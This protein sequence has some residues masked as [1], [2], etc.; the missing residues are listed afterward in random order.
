MTKK[1]PGSPRVNVK[2]DDHLINMAVQNDS[3]HCMIAEGVKLAWPGAR[4]VS[5]DLQTIRFSDPVTRMRYT[6]LTPRIAQKA[7]CE[8]DEGI[9]PEPIVFQLREGQVTRS[10]RKRKDEP[11]TQSEKQSEA[12]REGLKQAHLIIR[13]QDRIP[14]R[15]GG[16]TPPIGALAGGDEDALTKIP[17]GRRR[18]FGLRALDRKPPGELLRDSPDG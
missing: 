12:H 15:S 8:F 5:V 17:R 2:I 14:E 1:L 10:G 13:R 16:R 18:Q 4:H 6:Y 3:G 7:L 9:R 11:V